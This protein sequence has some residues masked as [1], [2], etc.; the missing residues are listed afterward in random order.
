MA[1]PL[2]AGQILT[3]LP[4]PKQSNGDT[5]IRNCKSFVP[6]AGIVSNPVGAATTSSAVANM[7]RI[8]A[9]GH[10]NAH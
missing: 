7:G 6:N 10:T 2:G 8:V 5:A 4:Q 1:F 3:Q 9:C